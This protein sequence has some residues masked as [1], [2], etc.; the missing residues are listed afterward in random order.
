MARG[1]AG[2][3][4]VPI[5]PPHTEKSCACDQKAGAH[6]GQA[7]CG[8]RQKGGSRKE[9]PHTACLQMAKKK[10]KEKPHQKGSG[11]GVA[12]TMVGTTPPASPAAGLGQE[13]RARASYMFVRPSTKRK[14]AAFYSKSRTKCHQGT[15]VQTPLPFFLG[16]SL[17]TCHGDFYLLYSIYHSK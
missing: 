17:S 8:E 9:G 4:L 12:E 13:V 2:A 3:W 7:D 10:E 16:L 6:G 5:D 14:S 1:R 11:K 15:K